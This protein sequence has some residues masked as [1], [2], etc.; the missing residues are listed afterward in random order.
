MKNTKTNKSKKAVGDPFEKWLDEITRLLLDLYGV[1]G[2]TV[3]FHEKK[4]STPAK[5]PEGTVMF[6]INHSTTY[7]TANI[8]YYPATRELFKKKK[9]SI[10]RQ[11]ITHELAH[12]LT[13]P[14]ADLANERYL[15]RRELEEAVENLTESIGQLCRKLMDAANIKMV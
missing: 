6:R 2:I 14:L 1:G 9:F 8:W 5:H 15:N 3:M 4:C 10:L 12:I 13:T 11:G 7:K